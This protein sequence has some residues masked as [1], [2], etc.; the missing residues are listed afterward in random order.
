MGRNEGVYNERLRFTRLS[1]DLIRSYV[2][3]IQA[4]ASDVDYARAVRAGQQ[5]LATRLQIAAINPIFTTHVVGVEAETPQGGGA[6]FPGEVEQLKGLAALT[7]GSKGTLV[8]KLPLDWSIAL[9]DPVPTGWRYAGEVGGTGPCRGDQAIDAPKRVVRGDLYLQGQGV[10][11]PDGRNDLGF[12]CEEARIDLGQA[13]I[14]G[15]THLMFPGLFNE[16]WLYIDGKPVAHRSYHEP[17]W[18]GDYRL[19]WDVDVSGL[20]SPG[21]HVI[22][23]GGFNPLHFAGLFRRPFLYRPNLRG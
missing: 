17:W 6:W 23:L 8:A 3:M 12:Y 4:S 19:D 20:M 7:D 2:E 9:R 13:D 15:S 1:F 5:A 14:A 18:T 16:A 10:L 21:R 22:T 11:R